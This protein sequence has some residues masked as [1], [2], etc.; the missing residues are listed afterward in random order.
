MNNRLGGIVVF[1]ALAGLVACSGGTEPIPDSGMVEVDGGVLE[2]AGVRALCPLD[3]N[4]PTCDWAS[5]CQEDKAPPSNC[6][7]CLP[8]NDAICRLGQCEAPPKLAGNQVITFAFNA[9]DLVADLK[10]FVRMA[11]TAE[12]SGGQTITCEDVMAERL[13]W[14]E[15]CY[16]IMDSRYNQSAQTSGDSLLLL[17]SQLPGGQKTLLLVYGFELE[18]AAGD[19]IGVACAEVEIPEAGSTS[20]GMQVSGGTMKSLR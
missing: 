11:V 7:F 9:P 5:E 8:A 15:Q 14:T 3:E 10:S 18:G 20:T 19:P 13:V 4:Q 1:G 17:F 2:D 6:T 16:N 12:T